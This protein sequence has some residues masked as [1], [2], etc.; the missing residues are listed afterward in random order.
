MTDANMKQ[1]IAR[2]FNRAVTTYASVAVLQ[3]AVG[4]RLLQRLQG[5]KLKPKRVL[6]LGSGLGL[7][8]PELRQHYPETDIL[9]LDLAEQTLHAGAQ[10]QNEVG[11]SAICADAEVLPL[12]SKSVDLVFS[13][14]ALHWC[15]D[16]SR[17]LAEIH[18][19]LTPGGLCFFST[20]GPDTLRE[21]RL[22]WAAVDQH[23]HVNPYWDMHDIGDAMRQTGLHDVV[24]DR[25]DMTLAYTT[26]RALARD[27]K[28]LGAP[29]IAPGRP[30]G[31]TGRQRF[32]AF[33]QAYEQFR[34]SDGLLSATYEVIFAHAW[35]A[36]EPEALG[37]AKGQAGPDGTVII[38]IR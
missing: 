36:P 2:G 9:A 35:Q 27:L 3:A 22:S 11:A 16:L 32:A 30:T 6:D 1:T 19:I 37:F 17:A 31:L 34:G 20:L 26:A 21:V 5:I 38:P 7:R 25:L 12:P 29:L 14:L 8:L 4:Q 15:A 10:H 13:N 23:E 33:E 28:Q 18:R 24:L